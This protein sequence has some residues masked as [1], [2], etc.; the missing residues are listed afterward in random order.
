MEE[1]TK[2]VLFV[3]NDAGQILCKSSRNVQIKLFL[4][5]LFNCNEILKIDCLMYISNIKKN[6]KNPSTYPSL[7]VKKKGGN[8]SESIMPDQN[9]E[10]Y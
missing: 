2:Y 8:Q 7:G 9:F 5:C 1:Y 4:L 3:V 10:C 6:F